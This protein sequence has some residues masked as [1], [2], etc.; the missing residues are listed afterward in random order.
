MSSPGH[1]GVETRETVDRDSRRADGS[2]KLDYF[3]TVVFTD[4]V[5]IPLTRWLTRHRLMSPNQISVIALLLGLATGFI[6]AMGTRSSLLVGGIV[7]YLA[8]LVDCVDG[9]L[10][11]AL[12]IRTSRGAGLDHIG[13][14]VRR[15]SASLGLAV[16]LWRAQDVADGAYWW[17]IVYMCAAYL[18]LEFSGPE[19]G[20][21]RWELIESRASASRG[22]FGK[23]S[24][25][26]AKRRLLPNPGMPDVQALA[27]IIGPITGLVIPALALALTLLSV[28]IARHAWRLLR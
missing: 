15:T 22:G 28:G 7:F 14:A 9:K 4:P 11:R 16:W 5:A 25:A 23:W 12:D 20:A 19:A 3:W 2:K 26:L 6:F 10:A 21:Q 24:A 18:F 27:F 1:N 13:D 8:F 17:A